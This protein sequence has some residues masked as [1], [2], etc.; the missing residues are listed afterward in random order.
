MRKVYAG[1]GLF[2]VAVMTIATGCGNSGSQSTS[3]G[4]VAKQ[5]LTASGIPK[6]NYK[7]DITFF[8]QAYTPV[9]PGIK[10]VAGSAKLHELETLAKKFEKMYPNIKIQFVDPSFQDTNQQVQTKT[11]AGQMYDIYFNQYENFNSVFPQGIVYDLNPYFNQPNPFIPGNKKWKSVMNPNILSATEAPGGQQYNLDA[12]Y[13]G[14][15]FYYNKT[16]FNKAGISSPPKTWAELIADC[17]QLQAHG[18]QPGADVPTYDWWVRVALGNYLGLSTLKK[19][20]GFDKQPGIS[21]LDNAI[22]YHKG[23]LNP[24]TNPKI[25]AWW[26]LAAQLYQYWNKDTTVIP[27]DNEP[28]GA[29]TGTKL[30]DAGKVAMVFNLTAIPN[31]VQ[32][33]NNGKAPFQ[34]GSFAFPSLAGTSKYA[35]SYNSAGDAGGPQAAFQYAISTEKADSS[36]TA[37]KFQACLAWLQFISTPQNAQAT[38]NEL[39]EFVPTL[40]GTKPVPALQ[41]V[42]QLLNKP[43]YQEDGGQFFTSAEYTTVRNIFQEYVS[44]NLSLAQATQQYEQAVEKGFNAYVAQQHIDFSKY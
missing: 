4:S 20:A 10:S 21:T 41:S 23:I 30:F 12:D 11:A 15:E 5:A 8:A 9:G 2:T 16:L 27:W 14:V 18:I 7:G 34:V 1:V 44:G 29:Q 37:D 33:A 32:T 31:T 19:I 3:T 38:I 22:A 6:L 36:M 42:E 24:T 26:P 13:V 17:K 40:K 25:M 28:T 35:T 43:W 39:G